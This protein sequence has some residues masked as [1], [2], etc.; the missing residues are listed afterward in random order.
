MKYKIVWSWTEWSI[1]LDIWW[2]EDHISKYLGIGILGLEM[3][4]SWGY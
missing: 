1:L 2:G 3:I 4:W